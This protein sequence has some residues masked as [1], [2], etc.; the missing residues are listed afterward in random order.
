MTIFEIEL[1]DWCNITINMNYIIVILLMIICLVLIPF[2][3]KWIRN[4]IKFKYFSMKISEI[5]LGIGNG[6]IIIKV[7]HQ[8]QELAFRIWSEMATRKVGIKID[9]E[10]DII[11]EVYNSWYIFFSIVRDNLKELNGYNLN[12]AQDFIDLSL[13]VLNEGMRPHLTKWQGKFRKWYSISYKKEENENKTPQEI[14]SMFPEYKELIEDMVSTNLKMIQFKEE[15]YKIAFS[16]KKGEK[17]E[18]R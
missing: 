12:I 1:N 17:H 10:N 7:D 13:R 14:Q 11:E 3:I 8:V 15:L 18:R 9:T 2:F 4:K 6:S 16:C 5:N